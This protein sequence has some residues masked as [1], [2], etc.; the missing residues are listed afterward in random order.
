MEIVLHIVVADKDF[1]CLRSSVAIDVSV[2]GLPE[3]SI[4]RNRANSGGAE[5]SAIFLKAS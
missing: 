2:M 1:D 4:S 5:G 3:I